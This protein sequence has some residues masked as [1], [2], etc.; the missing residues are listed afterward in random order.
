[1]HRRLAVPMLPSRVWVHCPRASNGLLPPRSYLVGYMRWH[2][3]SDSSFCFV[4]PPSDNHSNSFQ[5]ANGRLFPDLRNGRV[6]DD[7]D[8]GD[9]KGC[10][11][12]REFRWIAVGRVRTCKLGLRGLEEEAA[13]IE[14]YRQLWAAR[15]DELDIVVEELK[16]KEKANG[17]KKRK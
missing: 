17:R 16:R 8:G 9:G 13:W 5:F 7:T 14:R 11:V 12:D 6:A 1:M 10:A 4:V 3:R 2:A 15:F